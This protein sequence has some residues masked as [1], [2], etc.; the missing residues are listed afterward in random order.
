MTRRFSLFAVAAMASLCLVADASAAQ[1]ARRHAISP[2]VQCVNVS[3]RITD[4][5]TGSPVIYAEVSDGGRKVLTDEDG[6]YVIQVPG[7]NL[8]STIVVSRTGYES[9]T[10]NIS[11][12][13]AMTIDVTMKGKP[14]TTVL[15]KDGKRLNLDTDSI[16]FATEILFGSPGVSDFVRLCK[17]DGSKSQA[18]RDTFTK[19]VGP[20]RY[21]GNSCCFNGTALHLT[22]VYKDSSQ[23][24]V[25]FADTCAS[26][27]VDILGHD[28]VTGKAIYTRLDDITEVDFP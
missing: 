28:H 26:G 7:Q 13:K 3:G 20:P 1:I 12:T 22:A 2:T 4:V 14:T 19:L 25:T 11:T 8:K 10:K 16:Q 15:M 5:D 6:K 23:E 24:D 27:Y 17:T 9:V 21:A 18:T